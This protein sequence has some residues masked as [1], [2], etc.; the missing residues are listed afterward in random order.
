MIPILDNG[1]GG[2]INGFYQTPGKRSPD[3][4]LGIL[5]EGAFNRWI[6][7]SLIERLDYYRKPYYH[8]SPELED[9]S[10]RTRVERANEI[11]LR[12]NRR[13]TYFLSVHA[14]AGGGTGWEIFT[15]PGETQS[16]EIAANF[17]REFQEEF[18]VTFHKGRY[19]PGNELDKE[20]KFYVLTRTH[21]PAILVECGFMDHP[22]DYK[23]LW[24][25]GFREDIV[26]ALFEGIID[27]Y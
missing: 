11:Y 13:N 27:L 12:N 22:E 7:N 6:V 16:D 20:A 15:S 8:V 3:W 18:P 1:H 17:I 21:C 19:G 2:M 25:K 10:L 23:K 5:Y 24:D 14:N 4:D 9:V 26:D